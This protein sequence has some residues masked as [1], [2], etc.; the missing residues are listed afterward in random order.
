VL[1]LADTNIWITHFREKSGNPLLMEMLEF[2]FVAC[3]EVVIGELATGSLARRSR[4]I[5][6]LRLLPALAPSTFD[7]TLFLIEERA[8]FGKGLQW[9]DL[10]LL[11]AVVANGNSTLWTHDQRLHDA[12][13]D[14]GVAY[15]P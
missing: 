13:L 3:H 4:T 14:F 1:I 7:E 10:Q 15:L 8:L 6:D 12:A 11:C 5:A 2:D 9:N